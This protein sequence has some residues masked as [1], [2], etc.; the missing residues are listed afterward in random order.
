MKSKIEKTSEFIFLTCLF[1]LN[2]IVVM[3][4]NFLIIWL[5]IDSIP[6]IENFVL[7]FFMEIFAGLLFLSFNSMLVL[8]NTTK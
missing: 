3:T 4:L 6:K 5:M 1:V 8:L 7:F 2:I